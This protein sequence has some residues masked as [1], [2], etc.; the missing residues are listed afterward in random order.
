MPNDEMGA[1]SIP[2]PPDVA[3][4]VV[5][6]AVAGFLAFVA[7]T[8]GGLFFYLRAGAP[9]AFGAGGSFRRGRILRRSG[10]AFASVPA[11]GC[12]RGS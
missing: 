9:G 5:L 3:T 11:A 7:L 8:M 6:I 4:G 2:Q 1:R 10:S 12:T